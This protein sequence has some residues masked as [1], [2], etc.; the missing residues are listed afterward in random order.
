MTSSL[1]SLE[2]RGCDPFPGLE[3]K[4][5]ALQHVPGCGIEV[6]LLL[7]GL[8][9]TPVSTVYRPGDTAPLPASTKAHV[10]KFVPLHCQKVSGQCLGQ[11]VHLPRCNC[12]DVLLFTL[13]I[14]IH[15]LD[16]EYHVGQYVLR[17]QVSFGMCHSGLLSY[18]H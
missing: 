15:Q 16:I 6:V 3:E 5:T 17:A 13:P 12:Y 1:R 14:Y 11:S 8:E 9:T 10:G 18:A 4:M 2:R 7:E